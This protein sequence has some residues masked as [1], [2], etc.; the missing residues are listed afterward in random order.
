MNRI[1]ALFERNKHNF[2]IAFEAVIANRVR[3]MLT[4]LG[5]IFGVAAVISMMAVGKGAEQEVL[6]Q[7]KLVGVNNVVITPQA[8]AE[9]MAAG[10]S[11]S[12]KKKNKY[13][14]G[15]SI[16]D[17]EAMLKGIPTVEAVSPQ[18]SY[19]LT[20]VSSGRQASTTLHG[21]VPEYFDVYMV[22]TK[23]GKVFSGYQINNHDPV[24]IIGSGLVKKLFP[25]DNPIGKRLKCGNVWFTIIDIV[26]ADDQVSDELEEMGVNTLRSE[27][28]IPI[29]TMLLRYKNKDLIT[30]KMIN[31]SYSDDDEDATAEDEKD[32]KEYHQLSKLVV[33]VDETEHLKATV[34]IIQRRLKRLHNGVEDFKIT[35]PELLLK[36]QQKTK[37]IFNLV[38]GAIA[39]ISL[40]VGG[41]GIMNI[42]LA[43]VMERI[44]EIGLRMAI[45]AQKRDIRV[46]FVM[47]ALIISVFGGLFGVLLG[48]AL[49]QIIS[50][51]FEIKTIVSLW[52]VIVSFGVSAAVGVMFGYFPA[53]KAAAKDPVN[54]LRYE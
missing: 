35:V 36:Q 10:S 32:L 41:I 15:L 20:A 53:K 2:I 30:E 54:S 7:I 39:G 48:L 13:S 14:P 22:K 45:G 23:N 52:S 4:A 38:L 27:V 9:S 51:V 5:I 24:C 46:Q 17:A 19:D 6:E 8:S 25:Y 49:A 34:D 33:Q 3:S 18:I 29:E 47:E 37:N 31:S 42:M 16:S 50:S 1:Y 28:F 12:Q 21:V 40:I 11:T 26:V 44:K 43:S